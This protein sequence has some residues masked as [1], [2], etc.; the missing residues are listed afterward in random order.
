M[1]NF[2]LKIRG[3]LVELSKTIPAV[4]SIPSTFGDSATICFPAWWG[5]VE[6]P[7]ELMF[8]SL[9][10]NRSRSSVFARRSSGSKSSPPASSK[11]VP[12][13]WRSFFSSN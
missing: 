4:F 5:H 9:E 8:P 2:R 3:V 7:R 1:K 10:I 12:A 11:G 6:I 13:R